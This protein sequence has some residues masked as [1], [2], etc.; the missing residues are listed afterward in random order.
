MDAMFTT[1]KATRAAGLREAYN[2]PVQ[3]SACEVVKLAM[4]DLF[5]NGCDPM[6]LQVHDEIVFEVDNSYALEYAHWLKEYVPTITNINGIYFPVD[7]G[8]GHD[9]YESGL[10]ENK[11]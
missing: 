10:D 3:G 1:H 5:K 6:V 9:W 2:T 4:I 8:I 7:V 11:I